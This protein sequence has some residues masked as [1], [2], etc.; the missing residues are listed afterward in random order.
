MASRKPCG[1]R[2]TVHWHGE[3]EMAINPPLLTL[4]PYS[5]AFC[6]FPAKA[7][8]QS[9]TTTSSVGFTQTYAFSSIDG[10]PVPT[11][12]CSD[13]STLK[14]SG[15]VSNPGMAYEL[16]ATVKI[17]GGSAS[18]AP[19]EGSNGMNATVIV[20]GAT[21]AHVIWV[22][23]TNYNIDAGDAA[24]NFSFAGPDPHAELASTLASTSAKS[25]SEL[26]SEHQADYKAVLTSKFSLNLGQTPDFT[27]P[28]DV[29]RS[30]YQV[31]TGNPYLEWL[32]FNYGRYMLASSTRGVLPANLQGKWAKDSAA[33]W[34][35]DYRAF[36][37]SYLRHC[38]F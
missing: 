2:A 6:S 32:A 29:L 22:G 21:S 12:T 18:C 8:V 10:L 30:Q 15:L 13:N 7:C 31:D 33:P 28:T 4:N 9:T 34:N 26:L 19:I 17:A 37:R 25:Y 11:I 14:F 3:T 1:R 27:T 20:T 23:G 36:I 16:L 24:H 38:A 35:G 5:E